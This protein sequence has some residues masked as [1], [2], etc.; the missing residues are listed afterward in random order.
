MVDSNNHGG[1]EDELARLRARVDELERVERR[2]VAEMRDLAQ[3]EAR[4]RVIIDHV[5][6]A[7]SL[8]DAGQRFVMA[9][10]HF[11]DSVGYDLELLGGKMPEDFFESE[12]AQAMRWADTEVLNSGRTIT[13][14]VNVGEGFRSPGIRRVTKFPVANATGEI[15]GIVAVSIDITE[16]K[17]AEQELR[18]SE[19][20]FRDYAEASTDVLWELDADLKFTYLSERYYALTGKPMGALSGMQRA[21]LPPESRTEGWEDH[22]RTLHDHLPFRDYEFCRLRED[23]R[24]LWLTSCGVPVFDA[25]G[26]F[27]GYRGTLK[28]IT[29][30]VEAQQALRYSEGMLKAIIDHAPLVINLKDIEGR[31]ILANMAFSGVRNVTSKDLTGLTPHDIMSS[32]DA[33]EVVLQDR[34]VLATGEVVEG[35][36]HVQLPD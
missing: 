14:E 29:G 16:Q 3:S 24:V 32:D 21:D 13:E 7:L 9:N 6:F 33:D 5:P 19:E 34:K 18:R 28:D 2:H 12:T 35:V 27:T 8:K 36:T 31:Y 20:R 23:G 10:R 17:K 1:T 22:V 26:V 11:L 4:M 15:E 25:D 30:Q